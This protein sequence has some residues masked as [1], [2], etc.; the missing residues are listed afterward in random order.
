MIRLLIRIALALLGNAIG[1]WI[2]SLL[3]DDMS[4][5]ASGFIVA[6]V[7]FTILTAVLQPLIMKTA[8]QNAPALQGS[9]AL[10]TTFLALLITTLVN[11][12]LS[13]DGVT[14]WVL[15]TI[16]VWL[17]TMIAAW[18]LPLFLLKEAAENKNS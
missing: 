13:I 6:V 1:L 9:S 7:I 14:T 11:D 15:A 5:S 10:V 2:A 3:L 8:M 18:L 12:G 16:L 17:C 4:V